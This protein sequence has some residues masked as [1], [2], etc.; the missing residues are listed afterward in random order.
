MT[1]FEFAASILRRLYSRISTP[2]VLDASMFPG[3]HDLLRQFNSLRE[4]ALALLP[5]LATIPRFH[6]I[7][8]SQVPFS[9]NDGKDWRLFVVKAY[10]HR[11]S[12]NEALVPVLSKILAGNPSIVS[13]AISFLAPGKHIP[14]HWGPF[15][16]VA[17]F[18]LCLY[19]SIDEVKGYPFLILNGERYEFREGSSLL[20]DDTF[21]HEV[22]N[23]TTEPRIALLLDIERSDMPFMLKIVNAVVLTFARAMAW[24]KDAQ[25]KR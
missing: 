11:V 6:E 7:D 14:P 17:R 12:R 24:I 22:T 20:W 3:E 18:H 8:S 9:A 25:L 21:L 10:R 2:P 1:K 5:T 15:R 23:P 19:A 4:E 13:A 16:G